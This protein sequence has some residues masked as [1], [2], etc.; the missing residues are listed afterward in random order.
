MTNEDGSPPGAAGPPRSDSIVAESR[1]YLPSLQ[2]MLKRRVKQ[3]VELAALSAEAGRAWLDELEF[4][5]MHGTFYW[6]AL[7]RW[8]AGTKAGGS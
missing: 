7:V 1:Q 8:A 2:V 3:A 6:A 5:A 4:R